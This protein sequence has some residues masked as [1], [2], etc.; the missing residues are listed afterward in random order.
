MIVIGKVV[1][2]GRWC[3]YLSFHSPDVVG[4]DVDMER[5]FDEYKSA[6]SQ[7]IVTL[8]GRNQLRGL[9]TDVEL[10]KLVTIEL[11]VG[12]AEI[13]EQPRFIGSAKIDF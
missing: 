5:S 8:P 2:R 12:T 6:R 13:R 9:I 7:L 3:F 11:E 4:E 1:E 10:T